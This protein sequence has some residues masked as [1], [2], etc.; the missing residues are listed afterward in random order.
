ML[1]TSA[2]CFAATALAFAADNPHM[3]TWKLNETKS[4][5]AADSTKNHTV[6]YTEGENG[7]IKVTVD[8]TDK[9]GKAVHW[10]WEGKWDGKPYKTEGN[11]VADTMAYKKVDAHT[12]KITGKKDGKTVFT[13]TI[14]VSKDGKSRVVTT[15]LTDPDGKTVTDKA[16]YD[17]E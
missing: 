11:P 2:L 14:T 17:K 16:Y 9:D 10:T 15:N 1:L 7:M 8:G 12:N 4:K 13:G 3:G 6:A 5:F